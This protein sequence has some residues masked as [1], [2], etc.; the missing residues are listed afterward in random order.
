[1]KCD[2][3]IVRFSEIVIKSVPVRRRLTKIL[4]KNI[5]KAMKKNKIDAA[6][7]SKWER[8]YVETSSVKKAI[9][10]L[11]HIF[12]IVSFS[13]AKKMKLADLENAVKRLAKL[14]KGKRFAVRVKRAGK[15]AFTS[16]DME[17]KLGSIILE[18]TKAKV[19]LENPDITFFV[20]IRDE[21]AYIYFESMPGPGGV[22][23][24]SEQAVFCNIKN[25]KDLVASWLMMKRGCKP[26][27]LPKISIKPLK[28]WLYG[29]HKIASKAYS[30]LPLVSGNTLKDG[31]VEHESIVFYP[32]FCMKENEIERIF[33]KI[34]N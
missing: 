14:A 23:L 15:H 21:D 7:Y 3:I 34:N 29:Q 4:L 12:G 22:P 2:V 16:R 20:E 26:V 24:G 17:A 11:K 31:F 18:S 25:K 13:P 10:V 27:I 8:I 28:K 32:V 1:M 19:D 6:V 33:R 5:K 30:S 9:N